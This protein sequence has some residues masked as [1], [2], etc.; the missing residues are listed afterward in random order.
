M[1]GNW[2]ETLSELR[3]VLPPSKTEDSKAPA[4]ALEATG[5]KMSA[6]EIQ[7]LMADVQSFLEMVQAARP[8]LEAMQKFPGKV[9]DSIRTALRMIQGFSGP[10]SKFTKELRR[11]LEGMT[12]SS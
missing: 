11:A 3:A 1:S 12:P 5:P 6:E 8:K 7:K 10:I 2:K 4:P 9:G